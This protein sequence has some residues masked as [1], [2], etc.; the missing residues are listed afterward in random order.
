M[1]HQLPAAT[2]SV[3]K[4][5]RR[6]CSLRPTCR[7]CGSYRSILGVARAY[8]S[9]NSPCMQP[10]KIRF[11]WRKSMKACITPLSPQIKRELRLFLEVK[12]PNIVTG[13]TSFSSTEGIYLVSE[14]AARG[15]I[16]QAE[17]SACVWELA[18]LARFPV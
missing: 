6:M 14:F 3:S 10:E 16:R 8:T 1:L 13:V 15:A 12:H 2:L 11:I 9:L 7:R 5:I 4:C 18:A 17:C